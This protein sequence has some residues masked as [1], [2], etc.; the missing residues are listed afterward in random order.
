MERCDR[1][2]AQKLTRGSGDEHYKVLLQKGQVSL[3]N[4]QENRETK[5]EQWTISRITPVNAPR[6]CSARGKWADPA[7]LS[8]LTSPPHPTPHSHLLCGSLLDCRQTC[9]LLLT[10]RRWQS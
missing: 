2:H 7:R 9:N 6:Q 8:G 4:V 3:L 1:V 10:H 5:H